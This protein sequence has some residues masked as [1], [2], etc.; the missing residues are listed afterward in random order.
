MGFFSR[1]FSKTMC[2]SENRDISYVELVNKKDQKPNIFK[3]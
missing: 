2:C 3:N 1:L